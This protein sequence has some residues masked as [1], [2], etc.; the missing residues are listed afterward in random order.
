MRPTRCSGGSR[1]R[2]C[3]KSESVAH[4]VAGEFGGRRVSQGARPWGWRQ[5]LQAVPFPSISRTLFHCLKKVINNLI[6][7]KQNL[8]CL[9]HWDMS[10]YSTKWRVVGTVVRVASVEVDVAICS[11]LDE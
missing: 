6:F 7:K 10:P 2:T 11:L 8:K 9:F 3:G 1:G 5:G 4:R